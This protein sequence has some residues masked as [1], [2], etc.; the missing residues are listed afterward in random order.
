M[1]KIKISKQAIR[2]CQTS[3]KVRRAYALSI[4]T[5][6]SFQNS[7]VYNWNPYKLSK[8]CHSRFSTILEAANSALEIGI[9]EEA[10]NHIRFKKIHGDDPESAV[11]YSVKNKTGNRVIYLEN[12]EGTN[13]LVAESS[14]GAQSFKS[15][16]DILMDLA[17]ILEAR[18][19]EKI[20]DTYKVSVKT[21]GM[22]GDDPECHDEPEEITYANSG[23]TYKTLA[24]RFDGTYSAKTIGERVRKLKK[25]GLLNTMQSSVR[26]FHENPDDPDS[27]QNAF[28]RKVKLDAKI[29]GS[30]HRQQLA[31]CAYRTELSGAP[32]NWVD[33]N[34]NEVIAARHR[35]WGRGRNSDKRY[36]PL[37][38]IYSTNRCVFYLDKSYYCNQK[39]FLT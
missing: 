19:Q 23:L 21:G 9:A 33:R 29:S 7:V 27:Y 30:T 36:R 39:K 20:T 35:Y 15:V 11:L 3:R 4:I 38:I 18:V 17:I 37:G 34:G 32:M 1:D 26:I 24:K 8:L 6:F 12:Q 14:V 5:K 2:Q 10:N 16:C 13:K 25:A 22:K 31:S 28:T